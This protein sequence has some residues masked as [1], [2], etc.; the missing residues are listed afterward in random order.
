VIDPCASTE[1]TEQIF[2]D[3]LIL[4]TQYSERI[5]A[6]LARWY[7]VRFDPAA[8]GVL[9]EVVARV[10]GVVERLQQG[11]GSRHTLARHAHRPTDA[12]R[13]N[14]SLLPVY[15]QLSK[16]THQILTDLSQFCTIT[17]HR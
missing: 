13:P 11:A 9:V 6:G 4:A 2:D 5:P 12:C 10:D 1:H 16:I 14:A 15:T 7:R 8:A 3:E 17:A